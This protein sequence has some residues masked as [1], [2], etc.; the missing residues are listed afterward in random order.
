MQKFEGV[1]EIKFSIESMW[2][3]VSYAQ[4]IVYI[5]IYIDI[6]IYRDRYR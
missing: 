4:I 2:L 5:C 3:Y 1:W 6:K